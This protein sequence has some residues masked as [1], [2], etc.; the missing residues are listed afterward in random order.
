MIARV[1]LVGGPVGRLMY[2][3]S[4]RVG[5]TGGPVVVSASLFSLT[6][7]GADTSFVSLAW[8]PAPL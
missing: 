2:R 3:V 7:V 4:A 8:R 6:G 5:I 1:I